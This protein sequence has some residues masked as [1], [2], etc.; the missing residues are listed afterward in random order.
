LSLPD[1]RQCSKGKERTQYQADSTEN[2]DEPASDRHTNDQHEKEK[3][4]DDQRR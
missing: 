3:R 4:Q 2:N 1:P